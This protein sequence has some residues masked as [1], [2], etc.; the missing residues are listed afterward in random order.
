M[1]TPAFPAPSPSSVKSLRFYATGAATANFVDNEFAFEI[2][3]SSPSDQGWAGTILV[4]AVSAAVEISFDGTN[5]HGY[6]PA[7]EVT[8]YRNRYEGG[9]AVRGV[10]ATFYVEAW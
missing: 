3:G 4:R 5:V 1:A 8:T 9:I 6:I 7:G 2:A 10:G